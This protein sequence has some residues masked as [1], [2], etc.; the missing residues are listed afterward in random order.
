MGGHVARAGKTRF[1]Y[2]QLLENIS[3]MRIRHRRKDNIKTNIEEI[4]WENMS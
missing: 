1:C 2:E 3:F 4:L